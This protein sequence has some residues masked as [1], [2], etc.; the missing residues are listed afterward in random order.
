MR[1]EID[2]NTAKEQLKEI[3]KLLDSGHVL[4]GGLA[5]QQY[6]KTRE[7]RD[8]DLV[9]DSATAKKIIDK[10]YP[11]KDYYID[12]PNDDEYR[13]AFEI[14]HKINKNKIVFF[15]PKILERE[16]YKAID[17]SKLHK[18][19]TPFKHK[20]ES[21]EN[22]R[23]PRIESLAFIKL[24][25]FVDRVSTNRQKGE[26]DLIDFIE[27]TN[28]DRFKLN[29]LINQIRES[30]TDTYIKEKLSKVGGY[31]VKIWNNS[32]LFDFFKIIV[33]AF[34]PMENSINVFHDSFDKVYKINESIDFY[35]VIATKYDERNTKVVLDTHR[36]V[37]RGINEELKK[38]E[39]IDILDVGSG[40]GRLIASQFFEAENIKWN[41]VE[42]SENMA[43]QFIDNMR[44]SKLNYKMNK[45]S[46]F[47]LNEEVKQKKYDVLI[48]SL[49]L[50][51]LPKDP[52]FEMLA[53]LLKPNGVLIIT[54]FYESCSYY[55]FD[56][57]NKNIAL[58]MRKINF[59]ELLKR[60][61]NCGLTLEYL[62]TIDNKGEN[63][64]TFIIKMLNS[65]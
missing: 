5:V 56:Y 14:T 59:I 13:P 26:N 8:I 44:L 34:G 30:R 17:W 3:N 31:D 64:N 28:D 16:S 18:N 11:S 47:N 9:C 27:L 65:Q 36:R 58:H 32:L 52:D 15:G 10:L 60:C 51:S 55:N 12:E 20:K 2:I 63:E 43:E 23:V 37:I 48:L 39:S 45:S 1:Q 19:S 29:D 50:S 35:Q 38:L 42:P 6:Y 57:D 21:Y 33:Q 46:I 54:D 7:T 40:T 49:V 25:S 24:L 61:L 62:D 22:I 53:D 41:C 4:I